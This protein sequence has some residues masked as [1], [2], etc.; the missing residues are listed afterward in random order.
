MPGAAVC[1]V[2]LWDS[3]LRS[4]TGH[5]SH[6]QSGLEPALPN[7]GTWRGFLALLWAGAAEPDRLR[8]IPACIARKDFLL[9]GGERRNANKCYTAIR[10]MPVLVG[11][12]SVKAWSLAVSKTSKNKLIKMT[13]Q[14]LCSRLNW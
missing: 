6:S 12:M 10:W 8:C 2:S 13:V 4:K 14:K 3:H 1:S 11:M 7:P 5:L 9:C